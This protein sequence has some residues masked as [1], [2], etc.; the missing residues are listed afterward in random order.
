MPS[1]FPR[2]ALNNSEG[3][4]DYIS[5]GIARAPGYVDAI[6]ASCIKL[7]DFPNAR[8]PPGRSDAGSS[9]HQPSW[10]RRHRVHGR[11]A[12]RFVSV[13]GVFYG[14][15]D[16]ESVAK[17]TKA[18]AASSGRPGRTF[19]IAA[20]AP[21]VRGRLA[22]RSR[23]PD[24]G[25]SRSSGLADTLDSAASSFPPAQH[26]PRVGLSKA[27]TFFGLR[28]MARDATGL[29]DLVAGVVQRL[30]GAG[31]RQ[32]LPNSVLTARS[33]CQTSDDAARWPGCESPSAGCS[34]R[35]PDCWGRPR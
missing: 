29:A 16:Y 26:Q 9:H 19:R 12:P 5:R 14:G 28:G 22:C 6:V 20:S 34:A 31:L 35:P 15:R 30:L 4:E 13:I 7:A 3:I 21:P 17:R 10:P 8:T 27:S 24:P 18:G 11:R 25:S 33:T 2:S 23:H 1:S 32:A